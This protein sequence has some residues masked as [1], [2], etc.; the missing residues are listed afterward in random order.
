MTIMYN[1]HHS[2]HSSGVFNKCLHGAYC[3]P[4]TIIILSH[5]LHTPVRDQLHFFLFWRTWVIKQP[6]KFIQLNEALTVYAVQSFV[7][8][9]PDS[10]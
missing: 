5:S 6:S 9:F 3:I 1:F 4:G 7:Y 2:C 10:T 8:L